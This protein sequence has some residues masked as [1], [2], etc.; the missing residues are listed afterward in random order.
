MNLN[1]PKYAVTQR[2]TDGTM[3]SYNPQLLWAVDYPYRGLLP[4]KRV[5]WY[6]AEVL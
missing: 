3:T 1:F 2:Q 4:N 6:M 5:V